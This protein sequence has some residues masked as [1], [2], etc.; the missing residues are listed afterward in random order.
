MGLLDLV[1]RRRAGLLSFLDA[2]RFVGFL[3]LVCAPLILFVGRTRPLSTSALAAT[4]DSH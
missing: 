2:L 3:S 1:V 4:S